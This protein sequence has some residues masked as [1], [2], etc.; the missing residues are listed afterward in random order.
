MRVLVVGLLCAGSLGWVLVGAITMLRHNREK[1]RAFVQ[2]LGHE[3][4][5]EFRIGRSRMT[6]RRTGQLYADESRWYVALRGGTW[7]TAVPVPSIRSITDPR[8][9]QQFG[10]WS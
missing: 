6:R 2:L 4:E 8:T 10:P 1:R 5:L 9:G 7:N 3:V